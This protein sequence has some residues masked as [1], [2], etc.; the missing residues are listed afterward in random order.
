M[1]TAARGARAKADRHIC[2]GAELV[3]SEPVCSPASSWASSHLVSAR[4][5]S[6]NGPREGNQLDW[7]NCDKG[8]QQLDYE[9]ILTP[10]PAQ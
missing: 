6:L 9:S 5:R 2:S 4:E 8:S 3:G 1:K 7:E 10:Q